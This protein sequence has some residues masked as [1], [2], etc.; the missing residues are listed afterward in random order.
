M[1]KMKSQASVFFF[2][3]KTTPNS[4]LCT[5]PK[6]KVDLFDPEGKGSLVFMLQTTFWTVC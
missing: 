4:P 1:K 6:P 5:C 3:L 2:C